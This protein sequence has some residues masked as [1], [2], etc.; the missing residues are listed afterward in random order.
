VKC[1]V[2]WGSA[3]S[4]PNFFASMQNDM[5]VILKNYIGGRR[6][7]LICLD[8]DGWVLMRVKLPLDTTT[9]RGESVSCLHIEEWV[10]QRM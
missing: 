4:L 5:N 10:V 7:R 9:G 1:S 8:I 6:E 2:D 3:E